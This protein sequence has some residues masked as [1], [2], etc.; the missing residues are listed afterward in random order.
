MDA[1]ALGDYI[2]KTA[3]HRTNFYGVKVRILDARR[4]Y[5]TEQFQVTP[6]SGE[7]LAWVRMDSLKN[8]EGGK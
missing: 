4:V 3:I 5:G 2:G 8:I 1:K 7:G 6:I